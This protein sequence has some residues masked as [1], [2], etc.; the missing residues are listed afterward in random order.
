[1]G[2]LKP[3]E[4]LFFIGCFSNAD[5]EGRLVANPAYLRAVIFPYDDFSLEEIRAMRDRVA[6]VCRNFLVYRVGGEE[7]IAFARWREYQSP[8]YAKPSRLPA[9]PPGVAGAADGSGRGEA[10][11]A[12]GG[13]PGDGGAGMTCAGRVP[14]PEMEE[15]ARAGKDAGPAQ[16]CGGEDA[17]PVQPC[18]EK[19]ARLQ[20]WDGDVDGDGDKDEDGDVDA[21]STYAQVT[22]EVGIRERERAARTNAGRPGQDQ[23]EQPR[24]TERAAR[25]PAGSAPADR[26]EAAGGA[27]RNED[28]RSAPINLPARR[29]G[30]AE[31]G[32]ALAG[33]PGAGPDGRGRGS[34][35]RETPAKRGERPLPGETGATPAAA[36]EGPTAAEA[37]VLAELAAVPGYPRDQE[38]DLALVRALAAEF[39][40][41]DLAAEARRW[42]TY[43]LDRPLS[44]RSNPRLQFRNWCEVAARRPRD[45]P[46]GKGRAEAVSPADRLAPYL[47]D[48]KFADVYLS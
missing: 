45:S 17:L 36:G 6:A 27:Q 18:A 46:A 42:R 39:P 9:P 20:L 14:A 21:G 10:E 33:P 32:T 16:A 47:G 1:M 11:R 38:K 26:D 3:I 43:K 7:Y 41:L 34:D 2:K 23:A 29:E 15:S 24:G 28:A 25:G 22:G 19:D 37:A 12:V 13:G 30:S 48:G 8:R 35:V 44:R 40:D 4:R 5:D 31:P